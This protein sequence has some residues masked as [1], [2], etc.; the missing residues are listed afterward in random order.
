VKPFLGILVGELHVPRLLVRGDLGADV[1]DDLVGGDG[2]AVLQHHDRIGLSASEMAK[3]L[4][5]V[6]SEGTVPFDR[7]SL[8]ARAASSLISPFSCSSS[9]QR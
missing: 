5:R 8:V 6:V 4:N 9:A 7:P 2:G 3:R 1:L